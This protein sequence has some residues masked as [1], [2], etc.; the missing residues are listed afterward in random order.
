MDLRL[1]STKKLMKTKLMGR[2]PPRANRPVGCFKGMDPQ[3]SID[4]EN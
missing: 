3:N 1:I 4:F 2:L